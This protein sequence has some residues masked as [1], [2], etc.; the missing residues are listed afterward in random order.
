MTAEEKQKLYEELSYILDLLDKGDINFATMT[1]EDLVNQIQ[2][3][4]L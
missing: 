2:N 1:L 3:G 4:E